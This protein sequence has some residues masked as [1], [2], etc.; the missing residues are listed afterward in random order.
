[1]QTELC[2]PSHDTH[3]TSSFKKYLPNLTA[4]KKSSRRWTTRCIFN[5]L[6]KNKYA[7]RTTYLAPYLPACLPDYLPTPTISR[8]E[9]KL[10]VFRH[11]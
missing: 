5:D 8:F 3:Q 1:M 2:K 9:Y 11:I 6:S 4:F 7:A 10:Y